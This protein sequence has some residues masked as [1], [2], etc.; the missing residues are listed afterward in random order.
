MAAKKT[1]KL[2]N[3]KCFIASPPAYSRL[4]S[5]MNINDVCIL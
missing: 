2:S 1:G 4:L 5:L 3:N